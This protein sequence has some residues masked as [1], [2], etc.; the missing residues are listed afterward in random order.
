MSEACHSKVCI[1]WER[2]VQMNQICTECEQIIKADEIWVRAKHGGYIHTKCIRY[3][4]DNIGK[5][6]K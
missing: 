5:D 2:R 3:P 6:L 1:Q 4:W